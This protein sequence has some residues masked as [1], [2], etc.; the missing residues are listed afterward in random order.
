[1]VL[2]RNEKIHRIKK[3]L[4]PLNV[5]GPEKNKLLD[6]TWGSVYGPSLTAIEE[7]QKEGAAVSMLN[8]KHLFPF[9]QQ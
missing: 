2:L 4:P 7:L 3:N 5:F 9:H 8:L 6:V 1:M